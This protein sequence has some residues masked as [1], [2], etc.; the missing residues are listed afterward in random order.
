MSRIKNQLLLFSL[1]MTSGPVQ[2]QDSAKVFF[3]R[4]LRLQENSVILLREGDAVLGKVFPGAILTRK[5]AAGKHTITMSIVNTIEF[6]LEVHDGQVYFVETTMDANYFKEAPAATMKT[7]YLARLE[8]AKLNPALA[9]TIELDKAEELLRLRTDTIRAV[10]KLFWRKS[11]NA[12][13]G[14][15]YFGFG[16]AASLIY[17]AQGEGTDPGSI[18]VDG[19][20]LFGL[21]KN[22]NK[23]NRYD[24]VRFSELRKAYREGVPLPTAVKVKLR[25]KDFRRGRRSDL[26][27]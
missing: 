17:L 11:N 22:V 12:G 6:S 16:L 14:S 26:T 24:Y 15:I 7:P 9:Q 20:L 13:R 10:E 18:A 21:I 3:Y 27:L 19:L 23:A 4:P 25:P 5:F 2:A 1:L 8:I